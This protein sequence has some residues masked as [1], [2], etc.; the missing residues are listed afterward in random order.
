ME[1]SWKRIKIDEVKMIEKCIAEFRIWELNRSPYA[2]IKVK[3]YENSKGEF[4][5]QGNLLVDDGTGQ[6]QTIEGVGKTMEETLEN[7]LKHFMYML[8][9]KPER[10]WEEKDFKC[11]EGYDF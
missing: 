2:K 11:I 10:E 9:R 6:F 4:R 1:N 8:S 3:I 7:T 5:G